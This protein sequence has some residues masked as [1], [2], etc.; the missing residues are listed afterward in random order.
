[1]I[2]SIMRAS[3][4]R[5]ELGEPQLE[6][7]GLAGDHVVR[8]RRPVRA[9]A[10]IL[11]DGEVAARVAWPAMDVDAYI[12]AH[13]AEWDRLE[14][15]VAH[16][17]AV[18]ERERRA[19]RPLPAGGHPPVGGPDPRPGPC[20]RRPALDPG[21]PGPGPRHRGVELGLGVRGA[22]PAGGLPGVGVAVAVVG[23]RRRRLLLPGRPARRLVGGRPT[24]TVQAT[25]ATPD[26]I[27]QLVNQDFEDYY[28]S[29]P[30]GSFALQVWTNNAWVA[31]LCIALGRLLRDPRRLPALAERPQRRASPAG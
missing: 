2:M 14:P 5:G 23:P 3:A 10:P 26:Q 15:L 13:R 20:P 11:P 27:R 4:R 25:L 24:P 12:S 18:R 29:N 19:R 31:A 30:A 22:L 17:S 28:S 7:D 21:G 1:M 9:H 8:L 16:A 6:G